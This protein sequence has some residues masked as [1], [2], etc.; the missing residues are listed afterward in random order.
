V[1]SA[2]ERPPL[3][4]GIEMPG[5]YQISLSGKAASMATKSNAPTRNGQWRCLPRPVSTVQRPQAG[6]PRRSLGEAGCQKVSNAVVEHAE[7]SEKL[8]A[9]LIIVFFASLLAVRLAPAFA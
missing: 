8:S 9:W 7:K 5:Y 6:L 1:P 3:I 2:L 4:P